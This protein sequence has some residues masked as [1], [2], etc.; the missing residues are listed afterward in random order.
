MDIYVNFTNSPPYFNETMPLNLNVRFNTTYLI[1]LPPFHD[2]E[3]NP[4]FINVTTTPPFNISEIIQ[5]VYPNKL[6]IT[7]NK[8]EQLGIYPINITLTD[9]NMWTTYMFTMTVYNEPPR[10]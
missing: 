3:T 10:F 1:T 9:T 7:A 8:W 2:N 5:V 4:I 6:N